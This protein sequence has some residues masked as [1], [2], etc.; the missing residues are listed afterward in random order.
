M[1]EQL[2]AEEMAMNKAE[3]KLIHG[4]NVLLCTVES[5]RGA[6]TIDLGVNDSLGL[7][8][9]NP[10]VQIMVTVQDESH[11]AF[12]YVILYEVQNFIVN[13]EAIDPDD[14]TFILTVLCEQTGDIALVPHPS[15]PYTPLLEGL[16]EDNN[17]G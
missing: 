9:G 8:N 7:V 5:I 16:S 11:A 4:I 2:V 14:I 17:E 15:T 13:A 10:R 3:A 1:T 12:M 6:Y